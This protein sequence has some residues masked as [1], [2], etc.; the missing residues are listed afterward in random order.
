[1]K[2]TIITATLLYVFILFTQAQ[3]TLQ[4]DSNGVA[5]KQFYLRLDVEHL[6]IGGHH[7][8]WQTGEADM[9]DATKN[10]KTHCSAFVAAACERKGIYI[11]RPPQHSQGLLANAQFD[12]LFSDN[13]KQN[14][15]KEIN[16]NK[17]LKAQEYANKGVVVVVVKQNAD[18]KKPGHIALVMP[19]AKTDSLVF[20]EGPTMIQAGRINSS[21]ISFKNAFR[22]HTKEWQQN[23]N[24]IS[25]FY[26]SKF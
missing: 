14:G 4:L 10:I 12:W 21:S 25:F 26:H 3:S 16:E 7:I 18:R 23:F 15:W 22:H 11:L 24:R 6:W 8:N 9:P 1:M 19:C 17:L 20:Q 5:L 13:A 2:K